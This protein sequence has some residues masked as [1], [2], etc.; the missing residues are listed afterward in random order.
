M[1]APLRHVVRFV[2]AVTL[3]LSG[4]ADAAARLAPQSSTLSLTAQAVNLN[5]AINL[6]QQTPLD[7][8]VTR[9][10]TAGER[11]LL[12][13]SIKERGQKGLLELMQKSERVGSIRIPGTLN[14]EFHFAMRGDSPDGG[15]S[16]TLITDRPVGF[17]EAVEG[18]RT[19][20]YRFMVIQVQLNPIGRGEGRLSVAT[21]ITVDRFTGQI[22][23]ETWEDLFVTLRD[24]RRTAGR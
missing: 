16:I 24:V 1:P 15:Q 8:V 3:A 9:W 21:R 18:P 13:S 11:E 7:I 6:P 14:Y 2:A 20:E 19:L 4:A 17:A 12:V 5:S 10:S 23:L 22:N